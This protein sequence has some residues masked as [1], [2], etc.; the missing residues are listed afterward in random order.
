[1]NDT[2]TLHTCDISGADI[3]DVKVE[4]VEG[5]ELHFE[6]IAPAEK[7]KEKP[8]SAALQIE[9]V[10]KPQDASADVAIST[11]LSSSYI[12]YRAEALARLR[13]FFHTE[14]VGGKGVSQQP[15]PPHDGTFRIIDQRKGVPPFWTL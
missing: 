7:G 2:D 6:S 3:G 5:G 4:D 12:V 10:H 9:L 8:V 1:M 14:Q 11:A 13:Q 15:P